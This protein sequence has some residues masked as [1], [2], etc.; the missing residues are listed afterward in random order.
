[1]NAQTVIMI[2]AIVAIIAFLAVRLAGP[3]VTHIDRTTKREKDEP[4]DRGDA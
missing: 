3:S 4:E 1:M 2:V